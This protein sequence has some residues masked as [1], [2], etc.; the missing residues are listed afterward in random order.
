[1]EPRDYAYLWAWEPLDPADLARILY[2]LQTPWC[3]TDARH[4]RPIRHE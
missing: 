2:G 3:V 1:M 4:V